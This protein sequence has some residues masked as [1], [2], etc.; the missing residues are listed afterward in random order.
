MK[1]EELLSDT[2]TYT[3]IKKDPS[4]S[5][6]KNLNVL[7]KYW[8]KEKYINKSK[9]LKLRS[10]DSLLPKAYSL[11]KIHKVNA[12]LRIIISSINTALYPLG[13]FLNKILSDNIPLTKYHVR[14][15]FDCAAL[16]QV[17]PYL[18]VAN[19]FR[20]NFVVYKRSN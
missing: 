4:R 7:I 3:L 16:Y 10:S 14:N 2:N 15:G 6:E 5:I 17:R 12:S 18:M 19:W 11:P 8:Y 20:C 9:M 13:K 1:M